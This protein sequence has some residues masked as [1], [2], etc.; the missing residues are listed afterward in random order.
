MTFNEEI[1]QGQIQDTQITI[2]RI[3]DRLDEL[4][5]ERTKAELNFEQAKEAIKGIDTFIKQKQKQLEKELENLT[6][7]KTN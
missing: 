6:D 2:D 5:L 7:L 3:K 4:K 1:I